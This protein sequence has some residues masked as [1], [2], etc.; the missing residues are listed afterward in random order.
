M[1]ITKTRLRE[2][3]K[4]ELDHAISE[5]RPP[6][7]PPPPRSKAA[8]PTRRPPAP[9]K[10]G[11]SAGA[12]QGKTYNRFASLLMKALKRGLGSEASE[13]DIAEAAVFFLN[14]AG[15]NLRSGG[16]NPQKQISQYLDGLDQREA[17][18]VLRSAFA[19]ASK[20]IKAY[21]Q[22]VDARK[23]KVQ[24]TRSQAGAQ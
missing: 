24:Q 20:G 3:I 21:K 16:R 8:K 1:K 11:G 15:A 2:I 14:E 6:L 23:Q 12:E 17:T 18:N 10:K 7:P 9:P 13:R 22:K 5:Q 4:E 19:K